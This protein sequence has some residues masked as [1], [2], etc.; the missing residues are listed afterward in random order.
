M[1]SLSPLCLSCC[2]EPRMP[3]SDF[4]P[5]CAELAA[6]ALAERRRILAPTS[7]MD[8]PYQLD[9][10]ED[11]HIDYMQGNRGFDVP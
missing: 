4:C 8:D 11:A 6:A 9:R 2:T 10:A 3:D 1:T 5:A 7:W